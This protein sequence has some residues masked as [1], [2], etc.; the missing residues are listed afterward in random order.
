MNLL[1][2]NVGRRVELVEAFRRA[3]ATRG[4]GTI[5]GSDITDLAPGLQAVDEPVLFPRTAHPDFIPRLS[6]FCH[7]HAI[8]LL[9]P[10]ID[11]DLEA[12]DAR[13]H[14]ITDACPRLTLLLSPTDTIALARDKRRSRSRFAELGAEVP[15]ALDPAADLT[16]PVFAKPPDGSAGI[17]AGPIHHPHQLAER[18]RETPDLIVEALVGGPEYTVDVLCSLDG[19]PL[20]AAA[21]KRLR[22]R[23][24]EVSQGILERRPKLEALACK[25]AAGFHCRGP[26]TLQFRMPAPH[27]YVAMELNAR[28]GGGLPLTIAAGADWPG[29]ICDLA[30]GRTPNAHPPPADGMRMTRC[31]RSFFLPPPPQ[32]LPP[33]DLSRF[34]AVLFDL[35]DTLFPERDFVYGGYRA[36]AEAVWQDHRV[37]IEPELRRRFDQ[38]CRGD[39]FTPALRA[40]GLAPDEP[41]VRALVAVYRRHTP[42][43]RPF[44]DT[45]VIDQLSARGLRIGLVSDG[46]L[47][48]QRRKLEALNLADRF[49]AIV[50][51]DALG[52]R[53]A[54]K[55]S[56]KPF[57]TVLEQLQTAPN[58]AVYV[59]DN[60]AKDFLGA[61]RAG[62][63]AI[64]IRRP[65]GLYAECLPHTPDAA[66]DYEI[67]SL[68]ELLP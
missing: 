50:F 42:V 6:C 11:P 27:R 46:H 22:V 66:P 17:G 5:C 51:S 63:Q 28:M 36:V 12:L 61:R 67:R 10:T 31:D 32:P 33:P 47:E 68:R 23:G 2:L 39:L 13:R 48:V 7:D 44:V 55:P 30:A 40:A 45:A 19:I 1:F 25:L 29:W 41:T 53:D 14:A 15:T 58:R 34:D 64:R 35:D 38:G 49:D 65:G 37:D 43:I 8:D 21:R 62:L 18:L 24:G 16:F 59:A 52:G 9:I 56:P 4:G 3:L 26:V 54:W 57:V 60:P 20:A